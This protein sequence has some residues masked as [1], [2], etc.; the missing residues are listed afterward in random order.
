MVT[1]SVSGTEVTVPKELKKLP[2]IWFKVPKSS[3]ISLITSWYFQAMTLQ[4][5]H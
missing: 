2:E 5:C 3:S 4:H 1:H